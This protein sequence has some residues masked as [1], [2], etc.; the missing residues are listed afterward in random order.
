MSEEKDK[1]LSADK[2]FV[3]K[4]NTYF[5]NK[6]EIVNADLTKNSFRPANQTRS[7]VIIPRN[8]THDGEDNHV[9]DD[10][11]AIVEN[12]SDLMSAGQITG[13]VISQ[14]AGETI[15]VSAGTGMIRIADS[16]TAQLIP[17][18]WDAEAG[19]SIPT[20]TNRHI[21]IE[22]NA[23]DPQVLVGTSD[24][25]FNEHDNFHL[26]DVVNEGGTLHIQN[27]PHEIDNAA[28]HIIERLVQTED[29]R[30]GDGLILGESAD[31][32]RYVTVTAGTAWNRLTEHN[33]A[34]I[35]TSG[36][37]RFDIYYRDSPSGF[38]V[39]ASQQAWDFVSYD[40][41]SGVL[42]TLTNNKWAVLW[43]YA[44]F[45]GELVAQY[46]RNQ[47]NT[48]AAAENE[49]VPSTAP[50]RINEHSILIGR[51]VFQ[52]SVTPAGQVD[53]VFSVF[54]TGTGVTDHDGLANIQPNDHHTP[55]V[56]GDIN[57]NDVSNINADDIKHLSAAQVTAL[58]AVVTT[59]THT[60]L[61]GKNSEVNV[62]HLTDAQITAL[63][64]IFV[65][66]TAVANHSDITNAG[67]GII[68]SGAERTAL[69]ALYVLTQAK[70]EA[71]VGAHTT[72]LTDDE[73]QHLR[74]V[75]STVKSGAEGGQIN[76]AFG[77]TEGL[78]Q[79]IDYIPRNDSNAGIHWNFHLPA[80]Y[81]GSTVKFVFIYSLELTSGDND[82]YINVNATQADGSEQMVA[83]NNSSG[84]NV[85]FNQ[86]IT[87][88]ASGTA[89]RIRKV[90]YDI[91]IQEAND[92]IGVFLEAF[93]AGNNSWLAIHGMWLEW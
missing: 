34:A 35:D 22:Y 27:I 43:F 84:W 70:I 16:K 62:K 65:P 17:I 75:Y 55:T 47:Y 81:N 71:E 72:P 30:R 28:S 19:L 83:S 50:N 48:M 77:T 57:H 32:N 39:V 79:V 86:I 26:G 15:D 49:P 46:G 52:K 7:N 66:G 18:I 37:D 61:S 10:E 92:F 41:N 24:D 59:L 58:H 89:Q 4:T 44:E 31:A 42:Q 25:D 29:P 45:D 38:I 82:Y 14:G 87:V 76:L 69:H 21:G 68:I 13:G 51:I 20:D 78:L 74:R 93:D 64:A 88:T 54:M 2:L 5:N 53:T 8:Q 23:G 12:L 90:E 67:S 73:L 60:A 91:G 11:K 80:H 33:I 56:A 40:N 1:H 63:H 36:A 3:A 85:K 9:I 6:I